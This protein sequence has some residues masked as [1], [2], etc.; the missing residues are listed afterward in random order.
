[1][2]GGMTHEAAMVLMAEIRMLQKMEQ[3]MIMNQNSIAGTLPKG[4][5]PTDFQVNCL[6]FR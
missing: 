3:Q 2:D 5:L 4:S 6:K 1:M